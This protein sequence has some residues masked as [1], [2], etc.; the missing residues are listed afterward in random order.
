MRERRVRRA[1]LSSLFHSDNLYSSF[2]F[3]LHKAAG[4]R[5]EFNVSDVN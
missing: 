2:F 1:E 3:L 5:R 4:V